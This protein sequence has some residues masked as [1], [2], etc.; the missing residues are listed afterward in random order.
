MS[1]N[2]NNNVFQGLLE[3]LRNEEWP[4]V[5]LFK[6]IMPNEP[7]IISRVS[8]LFSGENEMVM[9]PSSNGNYTSVTVRE[10]MSSPEEVITI[11]EKSSEIKG[12]IT[13]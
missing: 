8:A 10:T 12:V 4:M 2:S 7:E 6:F 5:Y 11:Y 1:E 3:K 13:L 9:H